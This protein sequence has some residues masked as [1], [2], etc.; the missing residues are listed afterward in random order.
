MQ[1]Q[2]AANIITAAAEGTPILTFPRRGGRNKFSDNGCSITVYCSKLTILATI[3]NLPPQSL[4][5]RDIVAH[6]ALDI[7]SR[8]VGDVLF[9]RGNIENAVA[10]LAS[11]QFTRTGTE[12]DLVI[13][14]QLGRSMQKFPRRRRFAGADVE[15]PVLGGRRLERD[16]NPSSRNPRD[17]HE[18]FRGR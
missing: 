16:P 5:G 15:G 14:K 9:R 11:A 6:A 7:V 12:L 10:L 17:D 3:A 1:R 13:G 18:R 8:F 4:Q 2:Q